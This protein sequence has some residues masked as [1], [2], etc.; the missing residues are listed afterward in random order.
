MGDIGQAVAT[1]PAKANT[2]DRIYEG[3]N[4]QNEMIG[5][6]DS[7]LRVVSNRTP[8]DDAEKAENHQHLDNVAYRIEANNKELQRL[9]NELVV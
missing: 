9:I 7:R 2:I 6:L 3:L 8:E 5:I 4:V 1:Q